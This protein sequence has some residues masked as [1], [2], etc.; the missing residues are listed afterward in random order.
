LDL[1]D[2]VRKIPFVAL[3]IP[4][5]VTGTPA[6]TTL[7]MVEVTVRLGSA[8]TIVTLVLPVTNAVEPA[9]EAVIVTTAPTVLGA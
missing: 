3:T 5:I 8:D 1:G 4:E 7:G 9:A 6:V 2:L